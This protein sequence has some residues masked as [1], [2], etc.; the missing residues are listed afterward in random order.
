[1]RKE[2]EKIMS[3]GENLRTLRAKSRITLLEQSEIAGVSMNSVYRWE[4][5]LS[6]PRSVNLKKIA[7]YY[8]VTLSWL[9]SDNS[10][11]S[12]VSEEEQSLLDMYR[13]LPVRNRFKVLGYVERMCAEGYESLQQAV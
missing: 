9:M 13:E 12:L 1:M 10:P 3:L 11:A 8:G 7:D 5:N 6:V 4:H 2:G